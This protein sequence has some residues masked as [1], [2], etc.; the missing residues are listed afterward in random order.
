MRRRTALALMAT[1]VGGAI[2]A[3]S[4]LTAWATWAVSAT[5]ATGTVRAERMPVVRN[6]TVMFTGGKLTFAW[7]RTTFASGAA[8]GG[9]RVYAS[10]GSVPVCSTTALS[11]GFA[12]QG[13]PQGTFVV[14]AWAGGWVGDDSAP[15]TYV[16]G[17][18]TVTGAAGVAAQPPVTGGTPGAP[19]PQ[20]TAEAAA[21]T[22]PAA[23]PV[24]KAPATAPDSSAPVA[25]GTPAT[26]ES[27]ASPQ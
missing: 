7:D 3:G 5:P 24:A 21:T 27:A 9:Y 13:K 19:A 11:C 2:A 16:P 22:S 26:V 15:V 25:A 14:R 6:L 18:K 8:V 1:I 4:G 10:G 12:P 17:K 20:A 23:A